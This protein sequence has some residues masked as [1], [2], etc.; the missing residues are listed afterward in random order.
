[1]HFAYNSNFQSKDT[2]IY[3]YM[4]VFSIFFA[5]GRAHLCEIIQKAEHQASSNTISEN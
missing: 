4:Q 2:N 1:M 3:I 5:R